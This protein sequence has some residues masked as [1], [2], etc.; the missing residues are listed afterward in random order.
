MDRMGARA[1]FN[2]GR[3][4]GL[5]RRRAVAI[6][7]SEGNNCRRNGREKFAEITRSSIPPQYEITLEKG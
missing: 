2:E 7:G 4:K 5:L 1:G 6:V 3:K